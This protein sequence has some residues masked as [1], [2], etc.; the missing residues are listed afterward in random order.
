MGTL[1]VVN[2]DITSFAELP[3]AGRIN[4]TLSITICYTLF[5]SVKFEL[6]MWFQLE[7]N[8]IL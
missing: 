4:P 8:H 6:F 7:I 2:I 1:K 3:I 5:I